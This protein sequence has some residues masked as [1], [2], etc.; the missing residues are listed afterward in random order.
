MSGDNNPWSDSAK[1]GAGLGYALLGLSYIYTIVMIFADIDRSKKEYTEMVEEDKA[2]IR[3][4][5]VPPN[6]AEEW[7]AELQRR[8]LGQTKDD[9][10]DDQL[11]GAAANMDR[12]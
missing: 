7:E 8:I 3:N 12:S 9:G 6:M 5:N 2:T 10:I 4:L 1:A 11:F